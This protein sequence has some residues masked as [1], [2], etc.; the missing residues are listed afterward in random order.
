M[1]VHWKLDLSFPDPLFSYSGPWTMWFHSQTSA[2]YRFPVFLSFFRTPSRNDESRFHCLCAVFAKRLKRAAQCFISGYY[3]FQ[4]WWNLLVNSNLYQK[5]P[6][7]LPGGFQRCFVV[8][9]PWM[10][11]EIEILLIFSLS[12]RWETQ[13]M[14]YFGQSKMAAVLVEGKASFMKWAAF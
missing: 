4:M 7:F 14:K 10:C 1:I 11:F 12:G 5:M 8:L 9:G 6:K 2:S 3:L 13:V